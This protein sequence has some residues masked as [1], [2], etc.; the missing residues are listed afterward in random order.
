MVRGAEVV[1]RRVGGAV[2]ASVT[3]MAVIRRAA[4]KAVVAT[5]TATEHGADVGERHVS[6]AG[7]VATRPFDRSASGSSQ[8]CRS[9]AKL[10]TV[11]AAAVAVATVTDDGRSGGRL[12]GSAN[13]TAV[14]AM[15]VCLQ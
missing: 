1:E 3:V 5:V 12:S 4:E 9:A 6:G 15:S 2:Q 7:Q 13:V 8:S 10:R 11:T 14:V